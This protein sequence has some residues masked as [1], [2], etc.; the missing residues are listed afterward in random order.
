MCDWLWLACGIIQAALGSS[1][2]SSS[3]GSSSGNC[4]TGYDWPVQVWYKQHW[5]G[6]GEILSEVEAL[7]QCS[8]EFAD[9]GTNERWRF[10]IFRE[11]EMI[12]KKVVGFVCVAK[13]IQT[14]TRNG[15]VWNRTDYGG[16]FFHNYC[17]TGPTA[18]S[19]YLNILTISICSKWGRK[20]L[21]RLKRRPFFIV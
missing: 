16:I 12:S 1:S 5:V 8:P 11:R 2:S 14:I 7:P 17:E 4:V 3:S 19:E 9:G 18:I 15:K 10:A 6:Y 21:C 20:C 13:K